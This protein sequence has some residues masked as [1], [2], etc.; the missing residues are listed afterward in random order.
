[1]VLIFYAILT[2]LLLFLPD[3]SKFFLIALFLP[4]LVTFYTE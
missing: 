1:M 2:N 4:E 3:R